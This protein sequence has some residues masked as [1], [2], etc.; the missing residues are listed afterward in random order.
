MTQFNNRFLMMSLVLFSFDNVYQ[1]TNYGYQVCNS[2][3]PI[4]IKYYC[5]NVVLQNSQV[6][7]YFQ[8]R[9]N[10]SESFFGH[11]SFNLLPKLNSLQL[12]RLV[13]SFVVLTK[14]LKTTRTIISLFLYLCIHTFTEI[15]LSAMYRSRSLNILE[16][17]FN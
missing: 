15:D 11:V 1:I 17:F 13:L 8:M 7:Y 3:Y 5:L 9:P 12:T 4:I 6:Y 16:N 2:R 10:I 14:S